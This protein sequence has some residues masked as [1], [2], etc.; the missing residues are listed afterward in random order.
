M[1]FSSDSKI[2]ANFYSISL[3]TLIQ[4]PNRAPSILV[5]LKL[6]SHYSWLFLKDLQRDLDR[7]S[8]GYSCFEKY[9]SNLIIFELSFPLENFLAVSHTFLLLLT[10]VFLGC[11]FYSF[12]GVICCLSLVLRGEYFAF[13]DDENYSIAGVFLYHFGVQNLHFVIRSS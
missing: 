2:L 12:S 6:Y 4:M 3:E 13:R 9:I 8:L 10:L 7:G 11:Q 5:F 1:L